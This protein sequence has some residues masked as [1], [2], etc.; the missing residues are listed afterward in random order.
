MLFSL[1]AQIEYFERLQFFLKRQY[2]LAQVL[3]LLLDQPLNPRFAKLTAQWLM[4]LKSG[5][6]DF[7]EICAIHPTLK[8]FIQNGL[9]AQAL[10]P[11]LAEGVQLVKMRQVLGAQV[12]QAGLYPAIVL[13]VGLLLWLFLSVWVLPQLVSFFEEAHIALPGAL[14]FY[15]ASQKILPWVLSGIAIFGVVTGIFFRNLLKNIWSQSQRIVFKNLER[16]DAWK[17][18]QVLPWAM[19]FKALI[20]LGWSE[21][22]AMQASLS[23]SPHFAGLLEVPLLIRDLQ[24]GKTLAYAFQS[25]KRVPYFVRQQ[26][27]LISGE[28]DLVEVLKTLEAYYRAKTERLLKLASSLIEPALIA[29]IGLLVGALILLVFFPLLQSMQTVS[30]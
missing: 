11:F 6:T 16:L 26:L 28:H 22:P 4:N 15:L 23:L 13:G 17:D 10:E 1:S 12:I 8:V 7:P 14:G 30:F 20:H 29:G 25:Q 9:Q 19:G 5:K 21:V 2:P 27:L 18:L 3:E 24:S